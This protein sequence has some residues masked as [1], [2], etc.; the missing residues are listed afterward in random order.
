MT[1]SSGSWSCSATA[2]KNKGKNNYLKHKKKK[3]KLGSLDDVEEADL[4]V[5]SWNVEN[6]SLHVIG[7]GRQSGGTFL[8]S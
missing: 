2:G 5:H 6:C 1:P 4:N 3:K 8:S 7:F